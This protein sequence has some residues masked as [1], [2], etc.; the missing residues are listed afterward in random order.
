M[1]KIA[2]VTTII[3]VAIAL[4][5][6]MRSMKTKNIIPPEAFPTDSQPEITP[7]KETDKKCKIGGC[8][9]EICQNADDEDI[10][11]ICQYKDEFACYKNTDCTVQ[12]DGNC[13][14]TQSEELVN[15]LNE[16]SGT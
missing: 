1:N 15:C 7:R 14:W 3:I 16:K 13:G 12:S 6:S 2:T 11:S 5:L 10:M 8:N 9:G 4:G